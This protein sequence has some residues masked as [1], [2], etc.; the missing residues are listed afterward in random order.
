MDGWIEFDH[1]PEFVANP[2]SFTESALLASSRFEH[3]ERTHV[4][5]YCLTS[6]DENLRK[7]HDV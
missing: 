1:K 3:Q 2:T 4:E 6:V 5:L 7:L